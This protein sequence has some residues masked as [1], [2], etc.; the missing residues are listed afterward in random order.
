[1]K[2]NVK[3]IVADEVD[4][5]NEDGIES[6]TGYNTKTTADNEAVVSSPKKPDAKP[7]APDTIK[8]YL[9]RTEKFTLPRIY[10]GSNEWFVEYYYQ[11]PVT[12]LDDRF[13]IRGKINYEKDLSRRMELATLLK[14]QLTRALRSGKVPTRYL[15]QRNVTDELIPALVSMAHTEG[16]GKSIDTIRNYNLAINRL[17][18]Y[19]FDI[20]KPRMLL[21]DFN[22]EQAQQF[23]EYL[24]RKMD[25]SNVSVNCNIQPL[26]TFMENFFLQKKI[27]VNP[28]YFVKYLPKHRGSTFIA[29]TNEERKAIAEMLTNKYPDL[30]LFANLIYT[31]F[32]RPLELCSLVPADID[33]N[34]EWLQI[35]VENSKV[36]HTSYRQ[37]TP[38][39]R[40]LLT[41]FKLEKMHRQKLI[42]E[43]ICGND[44]NPKARRKRVTLLWNKVVINGLGIKKEMYGL[45]HTGNINYLKGL[46]NIGDTNL[47]WLQRQ[48]DHTSLATTQK[49]IRDLGVYKMK[50]ELLP[51]GLL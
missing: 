39:V 40:D 27:E 18:K 29:F 23:K 13:R 50:G 37:I 51:F 7:D 49:Y 2:R 26:K 25:L 33:A 21:I 42:F 20:G 43:S 8:K 9:M 14:D 28:F 47:I 1:M 17:K 24:L 46:D 11:N 22:N 31:C 44:P 19:L 32:T 34:K 12:G 36:S 10:T 3:K 5:E 38:A 4:K 16:L 41:D 30:Y 35:R 48:N 6:R 15:K 45:K